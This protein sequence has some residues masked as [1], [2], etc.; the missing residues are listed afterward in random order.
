M[1]KTELSKMLISTLNLTEN[2]WMNQIQISRS[3]WI[4]RAL[5]FEWIPSQNFNWNSGQPEFFFN[6][7]DV[8]FIDR[9]Q[10]GKVEKATTIKC[11][12]LT[13]IDCV[14]N[15]LFIGNC[16][17]LR[18]EEQMAAEFI[19]KYFLKNTLLTTMPFILLHTF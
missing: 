1:I 11:N 8:C 10:T 13:K 18:S 2:F 3:Y 7:D 16:W 4:I 15:H 9:I 14:E 5:L 12:K 17:L 19:S 6:S